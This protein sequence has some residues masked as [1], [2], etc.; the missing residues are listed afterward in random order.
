MSARTKV[1]PAVVFLAVPL[2]LSITWGTYFG[3]SAFVTLSAAQSVFGDLG[4]LAPGFALGIP[5]QAPFTIGLLAAAGRF[6]P[7]FGLLFNALGWSATAVLVYY[8]LRAGGRPLGGMITAFLLVLNPLVLIT[9]GTE[10]AWVLALGL[11]ALA[12]TFFP[13]GGSRLAVWLKALL[14]ILLLGLHFNAA[15][16]LFALTLLAMDVYNGR[17]G[18]LPFVLVAALSLVWGLLILP[19]SGRLPAGAPLFWLQNGR[20]FL[21]KNPLY[22]LYLPF[23]LMGL[24]D[25]WPW[26]PAAAGDDSQIA[27]PAGR[28]FLVLLI[29]WALAASLALSTSAPYL[30]AV[31][32]IIL[33]GLGAAWLSRRILASGRVQLDGSSAAI[34]V[35]LLVA[36]PLLLAGLVAIYKLYDTRP[37]QQAALQDQAAAWLS[38]NADARAILYAPPRVGYEAGLATIPALVDWVRDSNVA[39]LYEQLMDHDPRF[40]VSEDSPAWDYI[41][42]TKWFQERYQESVRFANDYAMDSPVT[43]WE[44]TPS[45]YDEGQRQEISAVV[46]DRFALVGYQFAPRVIKP[47]EDVFLTLYLQALQPLDHGFISGVHLSAADGWV[48][49]WR[50]ERTPRSIAGQWWEPGQVIP[51]RIQLQTTD[52]IPLGAY[53]LQ[54]FW[55]A[56]DDKNNWPIML[57]GGEQVVD[58]LSLGYVVA[59]PVVDNGGATPVNAQF[60]DSILLDSYA[61]SA[62][63]AAGKTMGVTL[64]WQALSSPTADYTVFVHLLDEQGQIV[65]AHDGM[66]AGNSFPTSAWPAGLLVE[67]KHTIELPSDLASGN[68]KLNAGLYMLETGE[69]LPVWDADGV[70]QAD[71][72]LNLTTVTSEP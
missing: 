67:D 43:V 38:E 20:T 16:I 7:Q 39:A 4:R 70:E 71:R 65:A 35:P 47:G 12:L 60:G 29:L 61:I 11:A 6:A 21:A 33:S 50:E 69:R 32:A 28:H 1:V 57:D 58:R 37:M 40:I 45:T 9:S 36:M 66:P 41:I 18:W 62:P 52:D 64:Y 13:W 72:S 31:V 63:P 59:P 27:P 26:R 51:E 22:W 42:R 14:L 48:W 30:A 46:D 44:Y 24:W 54:V 10:Y 23:S 19:R 25:L 17:S 55:R 3:D 53:D 56:G 15:T 8:S 2:I 68:Y 5:G 49:A 34:L